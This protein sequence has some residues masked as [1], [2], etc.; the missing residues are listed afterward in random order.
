MM[1]RTRPRLRFIDPPVDPNAPN[2]GAGGGNP[3]FIAPPAPPEGVQPNIDPNAN[4]TPPADP[5]DVDTQ[6]GYPL[7][8]PIKEMT[9]AQQIA[10]WKRHSRTHEAAAA[11][12]AKDLQAEQ[13]KNK[14]D[15]EKE[16]DRIRREG[17]ALGAAPFIGMAV[18]GELRALTG[19]SKEEVQAVLK[20]IDP[21][22]FLEKGVLNEAALTEFAATL[23]SPAPAAPPAPPQSYLGQLG[24]QGAP[25]SGATPPVSSSIADRQKQRE[26]EMRAKRGL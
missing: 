7:N 22:R 8:T 26:A 18:E 2:P 10:Y 1:V 20:Y 25:R 3:Q 13:D 24:G 23:G 21:A 16:A 11:Q 19:K 9:E 14:S 12:A 17:E 5:Q 4:R 15:A 6:L